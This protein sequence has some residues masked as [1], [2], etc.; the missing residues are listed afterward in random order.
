LNIPLGTVKSHVKR[1]LDKLRARMATP[2]ENAPNDSARRE[3][4]G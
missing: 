1:G 2:S 3:N 4:R